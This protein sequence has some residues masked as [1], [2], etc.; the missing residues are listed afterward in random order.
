MKLESEAK[1]KEVGVLVTT[2]TSN[3]QAKTPPRRFAGCLR[4]VSRFPDLEG[5]ELQLAINDA[6]DSFELT[7]AR[8]H[9]KVDE[10]L[11]T[12]CFRISSRNPNLPYS[13]CVF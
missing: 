4:T 2:L 9:Y 1:K 6:T 10:L 13:R 11:C 7:V 3:G 12:S 5:A 8:L